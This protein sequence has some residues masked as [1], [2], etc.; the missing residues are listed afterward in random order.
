VRA[1]MGGGMGGDMGNEPLQATRY[2]DGKMTLDEAR[3]A[4]YNLPAEVHAWSYGDREVRINPQFAG[5]GLLGAPKNGNFSLPGAYKKPGCDLWRIDVRKQELTREMLEN[6]EWPFIIDGLTA[7]WTNLRGWEPEAILRTHG[8]M[9]FH[10]HHTYNQTFAELLSIDGKYHMGHAVYPSRACYS[11]PWRPYSPFLF[12]EIA[13]GAYHVPPYF[14]P[15]S[16]F[17]VGIGRGLGVG[18]PPENHPSSW[19]ASVVGRKRWLLHPDSEKSPAE[20]MMMHRRD[21]SCQPVGKTPTTLEC[22]QDV[23]ACA[24]PRPRCSCAHPMRATHSQWPALHLCE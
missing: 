24:Q 23:R 21:G 5:A 8:D 15:M 10:L 13:S 2:Q 16:T 6:A 7:N 12:D 19:F 17:Q 22:V 11:D 1:G 18:V 14:Q 20:M 3:A 9:P 4:G